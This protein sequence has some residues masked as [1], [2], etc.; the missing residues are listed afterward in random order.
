M[1]VL[2]PSKCLE[3]ARAS[4]RRAHGVRV[5]IIRYSIGSKIIN[6]LA[7]ILLVSL[8]LYGIIFLFGKISLLGTVGI[9]LGFL[10]GLSMIIELFNKIEIDNGYIITKFLFIKQKINVI[11][12]ISI[13]R[14]KYIV[15]IN[16]SYK[17]K[18]GKIIN[19]SI[20]MPANYG[21]F[22]KKIN[23]ERGDEYFDIALKY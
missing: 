11:D 16:I 22:I 20:G 3:R 6:I 4:G 10:L 19:T 7:G 15:S 8:S 12:L 1:Q 9:Y 21:E 18:K 14:T 17:N 13:T 2:D 23:N 5:K